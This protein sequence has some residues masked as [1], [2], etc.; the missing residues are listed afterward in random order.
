MV[1]ATSNFMIVKMIVLEKKYYIKKME[2]VNMFTIRILVVG[3]IRVAHCSYPAM[4]SRDSYKSFGIL[5]LQKTH[6]KSTIRPWGSIV[7]MK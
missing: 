7:S 5:P 2:K 4:V 1:K 3:S 6:T